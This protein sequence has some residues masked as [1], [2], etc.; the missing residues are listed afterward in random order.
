MKNKFI[1][2]LGVAAT[3]AVFS[4]CGAPAAN[5]TNSNANKSANTNTVANTNAAA[6]TAA[7]TA[8]APATDGTVIKL[9]EAG[10]MMVVPKGFKFSKDGEYT[11]IKTDDEGVDIRFS[12]P[13][14]GD[15]AKVLADAAKEIDDYLDDVKVENKGS[16]IEIDGMEATSLSG[17]AKNKGEELVWDLT[18][19]NAPKKPVL[20]NIYAEKSS[21]DKHE[22]DVKKFLESV[23]KM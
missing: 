20:A 12:V 18:V 15:Y 23:K 1:L 8:V 7:N 16:K 6:N 5:T 22:A 2:T 14:D 17:T 3:A 21:L 9:E 4:A 13:K 11:I 19:I 10:I